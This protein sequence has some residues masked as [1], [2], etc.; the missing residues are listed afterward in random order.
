[1]NE[2]R[3]LRT[4]TEIFNLAFLSGFFVFEGV[5]IA[6]AV[7]RHSDWAVVLTSVLSVGTAIYVGFLLTR[8]ASVLQ[9]SDAHVVTWRSIARRGTFDVSDV[10]VLGRTFQPDI[11]SFRLRSG[12]SVQFWMRR[13]DE[14]VRRFFSTIAHYQPELATDILY[15]T[16]RLP[17]H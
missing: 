7:H 3:T 2:I 8:V 1:M 16:S 5:L 13:R 6:V 9:I 11:Y 4:T 12:R 14:E 15:S 10:E 17:W